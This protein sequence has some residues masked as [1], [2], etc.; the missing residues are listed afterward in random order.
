KIE[1]HAWAAK[2]A[3]RQASA[4]ILSGFELFIDG[5]EA[6][7][8]IVY[9]NRYHDPR[10]YSVWAKVPHILQPTHIYGRAPDD[11]R[12]SSRECLVRQGFRGSGSC[13]GYLGASRDEG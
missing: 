6:P 13:S 2:E 12:A 3:M 9:P 1:Q 11:A 5:W 10:G 8:W 7:E 4:D